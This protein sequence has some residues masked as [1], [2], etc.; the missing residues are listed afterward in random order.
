M[1]EKSKGVGVFG[2]VFAILTSFGVFVEHEPQQVFKIFKAIEKPIEEIHPPA[3]PDKIFKKPSLPPI[4]E[5]TIS[6][7]VPQGFNTTKETIAT[8]EAA[9]NAA[10]FQYTHSSTIEISIDPGQKALN[11]AFDA[12]VNLNNQ[13]AY[14]LSNELVK[15]IAISAAGIAAVTYQE[16]V[17]Q[18]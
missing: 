5:P 11:A 9:Y 17:S 12:A 2:G 3:Y 6:K 15:K 14:R 18:N 7:L 10:A 8:W 1:S 16:R 13:Q 4:D